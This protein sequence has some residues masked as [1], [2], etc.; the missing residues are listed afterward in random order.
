MIL[1]M[2]NKE[3]PIEWYHDPTLQDNNGNTVAMYM[4][5]AGVV[6]PHYWKEKAE[7]ANS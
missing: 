5:K 2:L 3:I 1:A 4:A 7:K 6:P